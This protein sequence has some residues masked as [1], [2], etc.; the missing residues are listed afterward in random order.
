M[1]TTGTRCGGSSRSH[2]TGVGS[3]KITRNVMEGMRNT[4]NIGAIALYAPQRKAPAAPETISL[5]TNL[6]RINWYEDMRDTN[7]LGE[8]RQ[9]KAPAAP[10]TNSREPHLGRIN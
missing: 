5:E 7:N 2:S 4:I 10:E 1:C 3:A 6:G 9:L 8:N